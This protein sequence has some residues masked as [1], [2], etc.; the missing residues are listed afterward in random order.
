MPTYRFRLYDKNTSEEV[1]ASNEFSLGGIPEINHRLHDPDLVER[2]GGP[3]VVN[4]VRESPDYDPKSDIIRLDVIIDG[5]EER[6]NT[7]PSV[8]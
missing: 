5:V 1:F 4:A 3:A 2:Y 7:S 8:R 6:L